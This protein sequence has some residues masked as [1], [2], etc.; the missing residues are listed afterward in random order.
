MAGA[1]FRESVAAAEL[2]VAGVF[3]SEQRSGSLKSV[4]Q[5]GI[6]SGDSVYSFIAM[7][8]NESAIVDGVVAS[9][10]WSVTLSLLSL[11]SQCRRL[12]LSCS[13]F[14]FRKP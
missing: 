1:Y 11:F 6:V 9:E 2:R 5:C 13:F 8:V 4:E 7:F 14:L 12:R 3:F 10:L